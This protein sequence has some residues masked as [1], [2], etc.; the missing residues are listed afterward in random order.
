[1]IPDK[2]RPEGFNLTELG[3]WMLKN[4]GIYQAESLI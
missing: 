1:M 3:V 2:L 4:V